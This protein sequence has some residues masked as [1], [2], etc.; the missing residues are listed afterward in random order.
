MPRLSFSLPRLLLPLFLSF[1]LLSTLYSLLPSQL[2][3]WPFAEAVHAGVGAVMCSYNKINQT[4]AC[5]N[6][7]LINGVLKEELGYMGAWSF[8][9]Y[10]F[11][12]W[13]FF[14]GERRVWAQGETR[15]SVMFSRHWRRSVRCVLATF[16]LSPAR[17]LSCTRA[18]S[19]PSPSGK[20]A[21]APAS[22][23]TRHRSQRYARR[24]RLSLDAPLHLPRTL[25]VLS[26]V[27]S[28][29]LLLPL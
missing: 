19:V 4:Q 26:L 5:Q 2:Y 17:A 25:M 6:S 7:K 27:P 18:L 24:T 13:F 28:S 3:L 10:L 11:L 14:G 23:L 1:S 16:V 29:S 21:L 9:F 20:G 22:S 12:A 8:L 15:L